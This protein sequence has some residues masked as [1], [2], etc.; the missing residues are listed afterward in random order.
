MKEKVFANESAMLRRAVYGK[1]GIS[2][3]AMAQQCSAMQ[4]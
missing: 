3:H 2:Q 1:E 4:A